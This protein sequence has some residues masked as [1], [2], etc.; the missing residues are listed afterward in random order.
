MTPSFS[1]DDSGPLARAHFRALL[2]L[3]LA[4]VGL[5]AIVLWFGQLPS[6]AAR[7]AVTTGALMVVMAFIVRRSGSGSVRFEP[8]GLT[9]ATDSGTLR[10]GWSDIEQV[11]VGPLSRGDQMYM[12]LLGQHAEQAA[13]HL[14]LSRSIRLAV[15]GKVQ[16][17][18][19]RGIPTGR[20]RVYLFVLEPDAFVAALG[21]RVVPFRG[22]HRPMQ[23]RP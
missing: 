23:A 19:V 21:E 8:E 7:F 1:L 5:A 22:E 18:N 12:R 14:R 3:A 6:S 20:R 13:V 9:V 17:T 11:W 15:L 10:L 16:G 2:L 4:T